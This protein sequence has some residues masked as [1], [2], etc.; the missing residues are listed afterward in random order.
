MKLDRKVIILILSFIPILTLLH[1]S[2]GNFKDRQFI[3]YDDLDLIQPMLEKTLGGYFSDWLPDR[4]NHAYP[5][6][7]LTY[8]AD[9]FIGQKLG[10]PV[11]WFTQIF[12]LIAILYACAQLFTAI[13]PQQPL[14][15]MTLVGLFAFHPVQ[16]EMIQWLMNRKHLM[17]MLF[18]WWASAIVLVNSRA[19]FALRKDQWLKIWAAYVLSLLSFPTGLLW[20]PWV[21]WMQ[22]DTLNRRPKLRLLLWATTGFCIAAYLRLTTTGESD[23]GSSLENFLN[24]SQIGR[25]FGHAWHSLGRGFWNSIA[26]FWLTVFYSETSLFTMLGIASLIAV[27]ILWRRQV[28]DPVKRSTA[29]DLILLGLATIAPSA[30]VF[31]GFPEFVWADRYGFIVLPPLLAIL[32]MGLKPLNSNDNKKFAILVSVLLVWVIFAIKVTVER[33][34]LWRDA[35]PLM[36]EC[37]LTEKS[38][39]CV[40]QTAQRAIHREGCAYMKSVID[41]GHDLY[42]NRSPYSQEF[43]S[44]MPFYEA[45]CIALSNRIPPDEKLKQLP[46]LFDHYEGAG[47]IMFSII[48]AHLQAS[49]LE[50]AYGAA[51]AYFLAGDPRPM[52]TTRATIN[53]YRGASKALCELVRDKDCDRRYQLF[54]VSNRMTPPDPGYTNWG[55]NVVMTMD[56]K[57]QET[58]NEKK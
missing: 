7:D 31:L 1:F 8:F 30:L 38:P 10:V 42:A 12:L 48:L 46:Y 20:M 41:L 52:I 58:K 24:G 13:F 22:R 51:K 6:R 19:H 57:S 37:A 2:D 11:Y 49:Q 25:P 36:K 29:R 4:N 47:E 54:L 44:E 28:Q 3:N 34:P 43:K 18:L 50:A 26:P 55:Y 27:T 17:A 16:V 15:V 21:L 23:Y 56:K 45:L 33:V 39:R 14:L 32:A 5:V 40:V 9:D 53:I 35:I